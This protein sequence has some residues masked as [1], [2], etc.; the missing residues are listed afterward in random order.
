M[1]PAK[2]H[3][4]TQLTYRLVPVRKKLPPKNLGE[5]KSATIKPSPLSF[6]V[7]RGGFKPTAG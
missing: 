7:S 3:P 4:T 2:L 1:E 5:G 6:R